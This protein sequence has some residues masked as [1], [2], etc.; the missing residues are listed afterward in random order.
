MRGVVQAIKGIHKD[1][2]IDA[3]SKDILDRFTFLL[4]MENEFLW[5]DAYASDQLDTLYYE[6]A[7]RLLA[8]LE[9]MDDGTTEDLLREKFGYIVSYQV[10]GNQKNNQDSKAEHIEMMMRRYPH[11]CIAYIDSIR[12]NR[13]RNMNRARN[14]CLLLRPCEE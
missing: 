10:Y 4:S 2:S 12:L 14:I 13:A 7:L 8:N 1:V 9:R 5:D 6:K 3:E 11:L